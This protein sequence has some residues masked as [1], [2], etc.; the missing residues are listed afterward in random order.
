MLGSEVSD[1][2]QPMEKCKFTYFTCRPIRVFHWSD[3]SGV[4]Q[5]L[6]LGPRPVDTVYTGMEAE[7]AIIAD[8]IQSTNIH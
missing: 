6:V 4:Q 3:V 8:G 7:V 1:T 2:C 5:R